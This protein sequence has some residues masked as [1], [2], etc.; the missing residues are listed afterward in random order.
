MK[1]NPGTPLRPLKKLHLNRETLRRL[2]ERELH[3]VVAAN[4]TR[5]AHCFSDPSLCPT[6]LCT[7]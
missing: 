7:G 2:D 5:G 3:R 1:S 6:C 4:H